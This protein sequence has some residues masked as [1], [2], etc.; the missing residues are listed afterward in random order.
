MQAR[1]LIMGFNSKIGTFINMVQVRC[2]VQGVYSMIGNP[3]F[4]VDTSLLYC[5]LV[6]IVSSLEFGIHA[7]R[8][9]EFV[10][11]WIAPVDPVTGGVESIG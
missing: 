7:S 6:L 2:M 4:V 9:R 10:G 8:L 3:S 5:S 1:C 11:S